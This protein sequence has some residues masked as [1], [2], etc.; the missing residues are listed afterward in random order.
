MKGF[1]KRI[2]RQLNPWRDEEV[3]KAIDKNIDLQ[4]QIITNAVAAQAE[5]QKKVGS[6]IIRA[7]KILEQMIQRAA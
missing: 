7:A 2:G 1:L 4:M 6:D 3:K 5:T